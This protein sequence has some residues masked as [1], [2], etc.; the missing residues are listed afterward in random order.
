MSESPERRFGSVTAEQVACLDRAAVDL[1]VEMVQLMEVAGFQ[2]ARRAWQ[3]LRSRPG[4]VHVVAGRGHN[5][6]DG[7]VAARHLATWRCSVSAAVLADQAAL[8]ELMTRQV[9]AARGAGVAVEI[10]AHP[11]RA[12]HGVAGAALV[13]DALLG[14]GLRQPPRAPQAEVIGSLGH[15][16]LN[17]PV[18]SVDVPSGLDAS[19]GSAPGECLR[20]T[21]TCTLVAVKA[22][23]WSDSARRFTGE[24][25]VADIGIPPGAWERCRLHPPT[26][27]HGGRLV[28]VA[29]PAH[30]PLRGTEA[31]DG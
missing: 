8:D 20:A 14:T 19:T 3:M 30:S 31:G 6:G 23:M 26:A 25:V 21:S 5:G 11:Q 4:R 7:L 16:V 28:R 27:V 15:T 12:V 18:L 2:V 10:S 13:I 29:A 22:G 9:G 1:G 17:A 24:V